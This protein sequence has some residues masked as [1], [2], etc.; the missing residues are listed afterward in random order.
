MVSGLRDTL[1]RTAV[2]AAVAGAAV[3]GATVMADTTPVESVPFRTVADPG[4]DMFGWRHPMCAGGAFGP[5]ADDGIPGDNAAEGGI[6]APAMVPNIDGSLSP[7]GTPG[8]I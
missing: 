4:C 2:A 7:P 6:P 1:T 5:P 8:A 3:M